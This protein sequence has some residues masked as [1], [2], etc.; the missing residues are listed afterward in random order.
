MRIARRVDRVEA[1]GEE[2]RRLAAMAR[3]VADRCGVTVEEVVA[4]ARRLRDEAWVQGVAP[5]AIVAREH[6]TGVAEVRAEA[7]RLLAEAGA[8]IP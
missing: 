6:H 2:R 8:V 7:A 5:E 4:E 3:W 1:A